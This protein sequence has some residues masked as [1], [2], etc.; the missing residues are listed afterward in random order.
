MSFFHTDDYLFVLSV[1]GQRQN[2]SS[3]QGKDEDGNIQSYYLLGRVSFY[4]KKAAWAINIYIKAWREGTRGRRDG[5][6]G[7][8]GCWIVK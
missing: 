7:I 4:L 1:D 5:R 6:G 3:V 8:G 2:G